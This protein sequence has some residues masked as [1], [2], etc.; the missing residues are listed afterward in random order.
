M[1]RVVIYSDVAGH[2]EPLK[3]SLIRH[4]EVENNRIPDDTVLVF[5][6]DLVHKGPDSLGVLQLVEKLRTRNAGQVIVTMGNHESYHHPR[7][8]HRSF[9][10][11]AIKTIGD[12][13][14]A[15]K[16]QEWFREDVFKIAVGFRV[17][18]LRD[19]PLLPAGILPKIHEVSE[20]TSD[21]TSDRDSAKTFDTSESFSVSSSTV[22]SFAQFPATADN[23]DSS[24]N[25]PQLTDVL[26]SHAGLTHGFWKFLQSPTGLSEV[27]EKLNSL[28]Q[29]LASP[30]WW[31]GVITS[32]KRNDMAGPLWATAG[33]ELCLSWMDAIAD[34]HN[35]LT[36]MPFNQLHGHSLPLYED[37]R[38]KVDPR[39]TEVVR[40]DFVKLHSFADIGGRVIIGSDPKHD[41]EPAV[42]WEPY[43]FENAEIVLP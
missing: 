4:A 19:N 34:P 31:S 9:G 39:L 42:S 3:D 30:L 29:E 17:P 21:K 37:S 22:N 12:P 1:S 23:S 40:T 43:V 32:G 10:V 33:M 26:V 7:A 15:S 5:N 25:S 20:N 16:L 18:A 38:F 6:G 24:E 2:L 14:A 36:E 27:V 35:D 11:P 8:N 28:P 41:A 13:R